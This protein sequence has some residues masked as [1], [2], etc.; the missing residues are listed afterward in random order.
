MVKMVLL[1]LKTEDNDDMS[2]A[3]MTASIKPLAPTGMRRITRVGYAM[4]V[5]PAL[6]SQ[7]LSHKSGSAQPISSLKNN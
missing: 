3:S 4:F 1:L 7:T 5:Q 6:E 2:A